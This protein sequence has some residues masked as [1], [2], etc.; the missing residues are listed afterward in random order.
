VNARDVLG[1][2]LRDAIEQLVD[3]RVEQRLAEIGATKH[4]HQSPLLTIPETAELLRCKRQRV[5]D[6]LCSRRLTRIKEGSRT[7]IA[8]DEIDQYL[9]NHGR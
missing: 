2:A 6:L 7:L 9:Q 8:R 4:E 3:E 5:D 1:P